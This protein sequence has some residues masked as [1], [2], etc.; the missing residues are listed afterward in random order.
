MENMRTITRE[1]DHL[2]MI[3]PT[4]IAT[5]D[6]DLATMTIIILIAK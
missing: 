1:R 4:D 5:R 6:E 2:K 3:D